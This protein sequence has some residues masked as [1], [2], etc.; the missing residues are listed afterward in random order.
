MRFGERDI[1]KETE[2]ER[3]RHMQ[4][5]I[6]P[7]TSSTQYVIREERPI[8]KELETSGGKGETVSISHPYASLESLIILILYYHLPNCVANI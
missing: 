1:G 8:E 7:P 4:D 3:D 2:Y 5:R 6:G